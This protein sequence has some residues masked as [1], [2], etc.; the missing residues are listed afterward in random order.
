M[1]LLNTKYPHKLCLLKYLLIQRF[2]HLSTSIFIDC[3]ETEKKFL[4]F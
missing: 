3:K 2:P 4:I 1:L